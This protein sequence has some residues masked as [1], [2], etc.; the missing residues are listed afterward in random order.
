MT[1]R[2]LIMFLRRHNQSNLTFISWHS[3]SHPTTKTSLL[4]YS[5]TAIYFIIIN[6]LLKSLHS[7]SITCDLTML[8]RYAFL[9]LQSMVSNQEL[10][11][12]SLKEIIYFKYIFLVLILIFKNRLIDHSQLLKARIFSRYDK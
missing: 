7:K 3:L 4:Y 2:C 8:K 10:I 1:Q 11:H 9:T 5:H 6:Y 12:C